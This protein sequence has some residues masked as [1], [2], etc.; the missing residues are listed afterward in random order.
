MAESG[1]HRARLR[2]S[3]AN[4]QRRLSTIQPNLESI[5]SLAQ[6]IL[7][8]APT[9]ASSLVQ[10]WVQVFIESDRERRLHLLYVANE[11][12]QHARHRLPV[13]TLEQLASLFFAGLENH[14]DVLF[15]DERFGKLMDVW[16]SRQVFTEEQLD[17][18][19][20]RMK[21]RLEWRARVQDAGKHIEAAIASS[22]DS[23]SREVS[24]AQARN[25]EGVV[26][27]LEEALQLVKRYLDGPDECASPE[28]RPNEDGSK[29][30]TAFV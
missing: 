4:F 26:I 16:Q 25:V 5:Q 22:K 10:E 28:G 24:D 1:E 13:S 19:R 6:F 7:F 17:R 3:R 12:L 9:F 15:G 2:Y 21:E 20:R 29:S 11:V 30:E 8:M 27:K 14:L 23:E 18:L